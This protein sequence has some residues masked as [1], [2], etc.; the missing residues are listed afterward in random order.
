MHTRLNN[1]RGITLVAL[2][3]TI[4][5]LLIL[6]GI[7]IASLTGNGLFEKAKLAKERQENAQAKEDETLGEY[8]NKIGE[9]VEGTREQG[10]C[11]EIYSLEEQVIGTWIDGKPLYRKVIR[12]QI[13]ATG[14]REYFLSQSVPE[15]E[16]YIIESAFVFS[17]SSYTGSGMAVGSANLTSQYDISFTSFN[18]KTGRIWLIRGASTPSYLQL[19]VKYTKTTDIK[20]NN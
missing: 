19:I 2:V 3:I 7:S 11:N 4:V 6:A 13:T 18:L 8:E 20:K 14:S 9:F 10:N 12:E 17:D 16:S 15:A 5:I 1:R